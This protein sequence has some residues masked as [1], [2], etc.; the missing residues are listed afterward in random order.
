[1]TLSQVEEQV[2][3]AVAEAWSFRSTWPLPWARPWP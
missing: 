3:V 2:D 1:M